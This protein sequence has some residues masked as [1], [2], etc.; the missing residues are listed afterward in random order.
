M[1]PNIS[2]IL[3]TGLL[4]PAPIDARL[5]RADL[6]L[7]EADPPDTEPDERGQDGPSTHPL[8][9]TR[10][11]EFGCSLHCSIIGTCLTTAELRHVLLKLKVDS[12]DASSDHELHAMGVMLAGRREGGARFLQKALDRRHRA[13][14]TRFARA[15]DP[16]AVLSLWDEALKQG[17][18]PG[19][20]WA[21]LTHPATAEDLVKRVFG[22]VHMLSHL[23][24]A[25]NRADIRRLRQLEQENVALAAKVERQQRQLRDGF[26]AR[27]HT[28]RHLNE[29]VALHA[30]ERGEQAD[31]RANAEH[32]DATDNLIRGLNNKLSRETA[33]R[34]RSE[35]RTVELAAMLKAKEGALEASRRQQDATLRELET[36]EAHLAAFGQSEAGGLEN[37]ADLSGV[38]ILYVGGRAHQ[39]PQL[40]GL[41][42]R[43]GAR[44]LHHD[45]GIEHSS[46][47]LGGAVSRADHVLFP[48][49]CIS[50]DAVTT[51]KRL[52]RL[53]GKDYE[54]LRTASLACL[55]SA[56]VRIA[57]CRQGV[58]AE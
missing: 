58:A 40:K 13:A 6:I 12:A 2:H 7:R 14:I 35:Q 50:H 22:D 28:I 20:Y 43:V 54:P 52:C 4:R 38:T 45:G 11:W 29:M 15:K 53:A 25:A 42:E 19:A 5:A 16:A 21:V 27:D 32:A 10:I 55:L 46:G 36:V 47:L 17:D 49:D 48:I 26:T 31:P 37:A 44:F 51:I 18:I 9:R 34:E 39:V 24:G 33:R 23:M 30:G 57:T 56:L 8:R 3:S 1:A 41:I